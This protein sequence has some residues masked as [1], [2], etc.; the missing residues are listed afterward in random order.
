MAT[1]RDHLIRDVFELRRDVTWWQK[2]EPQL[3]ELGLDAASIQ[4][5]SQAWNEDIERK[6]WARWQKEAARF[7]NAVLDD[8]RM[9]CI[10]HLDSLGMLQWQRD[11]AASEREQ[12]QRLL[13]GTVDRE[14]KP[15]ERSLEKGRGL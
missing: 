15:P 1:L 14:E 2:V 10:D 12:F 9:D 11:K 3:K 6:D 4:G 7:S 8:M 13:N 5:Y